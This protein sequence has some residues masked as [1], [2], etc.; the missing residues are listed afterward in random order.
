MAKH[1]SRELLN[2][3]P[4]NI[5]TIAEHIRQV[6][7]NKNYKVIVE[8]LETGGCD[9]I[10][11]ENTWGASYQL[12]ITMKPH[13]DSYIDFYARN[14][15]NISNWIML[16]ACLILPIAW[17]IFVIFLIRWSKQNKLDN[18]ALSVAK[19]AINSLSK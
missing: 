14:D 19:D 2:T 1:E 3:S 8:Y 13:G 9:I 11:S 6:F 10:M 18:Q 15:N 4:K 5:T 12:H 16:I 7:V 17:P